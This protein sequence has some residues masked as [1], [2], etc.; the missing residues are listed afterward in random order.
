VLPTPTVL[1]LG[2]VEDVRKCITTD[3]KK[4]GNLLYLVGETKEEFGGSAVYRRYAERAVWSRRSSR[5]A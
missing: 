2:I 4:E 5:N 1:G 3:L